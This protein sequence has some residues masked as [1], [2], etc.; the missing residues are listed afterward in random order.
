[1]T[2][3]KAPSQKTA[4]HKSHGIQEEG[5][6]ISGEPKW[7]QPNFGTAKILA[8]KFQESGNCGTQI[9]GEP[10]YWHPNIGKVKIVAPKSHEAI[11]DHT[12]FH[13]V[14]DGKRRAPPVSASPCPKHYCI[15]FRN[16]WYNVMQVYSEPNPVE[17][18]EYLLRSRKQ[19]HRGT[20]QH[21]P[22]S[23]LCVMCQ[24]GTPERN[25]KN[26]KGLIVTAA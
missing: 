14:Q 8:A 9:S 15:P 3:E 6:Q 23:C 21:S 24:C 1:M 18:N 5:T 10:K 4:A 12:K 7:W 22:P 17:F 20:A 19:L 16:H 13:M 26:I 11:L 2:V 25:E